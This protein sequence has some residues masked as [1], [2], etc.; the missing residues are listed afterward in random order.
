MSNP[1]KLEYLKQEFLKNANLCVFH[2]EPFSQAEEYLAQY[3]S[4]LTGIRENI[5]QAKNI[6]EFKLVSEA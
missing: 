3:Q 5:N 6:E 4:E 2:K 1:T